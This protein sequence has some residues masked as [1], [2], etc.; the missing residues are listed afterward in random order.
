MTLVVLKRAVERGRSLAHVESA[1]MG[2]YKRDQ[3]MLMSLPPL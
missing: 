1:P 3:F 2:R